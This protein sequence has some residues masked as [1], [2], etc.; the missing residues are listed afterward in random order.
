MGHPGE[1]FQKPGCLLCIC[2]NAK[3]QKCHHLKDCGADAEHQENLLKNGIETDSDLSLSAVRATITNSTNP[4][5]VALKENYESLNAV[6]Q[7]GGGTLPKKVK[8]PKSLE[9]N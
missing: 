9:V 5:G 2:Y 6:L 7:A 3:R 8:K 1:L 4:F